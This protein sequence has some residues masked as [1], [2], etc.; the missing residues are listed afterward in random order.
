[1]IKSYKEKHITWRIEWKEEIKVR[2]E[3]KKIEERLKVE[4]TFEIKQS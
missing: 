3:R 4:I 2:K 1:M